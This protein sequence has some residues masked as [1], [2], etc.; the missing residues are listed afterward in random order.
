MTR[1]GFAGL[2]VGGT[3]ALAG[4]GAAGFGTFTA[5][6]IVKTA[7][8]IAERTPTPSEPARVTTAAPA[9]NFA[10][11]DAKLPEPALP[12]T[13]ALVTNLAPAEAKPPEPALA[14]TAAP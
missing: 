4:W 9:T 14:T 11:A 8:S 6:H 2:A 5:S 10:P 1:R 13:A 12:T 7:A 3:V